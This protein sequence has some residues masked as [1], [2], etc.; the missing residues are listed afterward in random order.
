MTNFSDSH[1]LKEA[2]SQQSSIE[3]IITPPLKITFNW[4]TFLTF[5]GIDDL[6]KNFPAFDSSNELYRIMM[7]VIESNPPKEV[8]FDLFDQ[9]F[10]DCLT[11]IKAIPEVDANYLTGELRAKEKPAF[12]AESLLQWELALTENPK[13]F[14]H[15]LTLYL[16][17]DRVCVRL[18]ILFE[19]V[20]DTV[21][22]REW[23]QMLRG[24]LAESFQH[25]SRQGRTEPSFFRLQE[26]LYAY[27][28][29]DDMLQKHTE[30]AWEILTKGAMSLSS[31]EKAPELGFLDRS[32]TDKAYNTTGTIFCAESEEKILAGWNLAK[33][34]LLTFETDFPEWDF[35]LADTSITF[36]HF[37]GPRWR[38][39]ELTLTN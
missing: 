19:T 30:A 20:P 8:Y 32:V 34:Y 22:S 4:P 39:N 2:L 3:G 17:W 31:R 37:D 13:I 9:L 16:G 10:V 35:H 15:D 27:D 25:I 28:M 24:C 14:L 5:L 11:H 26:A 38:L 1:F 21:T 12:L 18:A 36:V 7:E 23:Y 6:L 33:Y 29:R